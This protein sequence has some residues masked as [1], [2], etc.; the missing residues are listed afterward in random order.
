MHTQ[1]K[2]RITPDAYLEHERQAATKS[3]YLAGEIHALA[4][5]SERH[6]LIA[7]NAAYLLVGQLKGRPCKT[8]SND[9]RIKVD[10]SGL[11]T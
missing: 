10:F 7:I 1:A 6:N 4:G 11:Y 2:Q 5:A 9:M 3:E 8:Y